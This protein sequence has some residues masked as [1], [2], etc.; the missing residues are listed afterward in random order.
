MPAG[1]HKNAAPSG[2]RSAGQSASL[3]NPAHL[4]RAARAALAPAIVTGRPR[5]QGRLGGANRRRRERGIERGAGL[6]AGGQ[7][8]TNCVPDSLPRRRIA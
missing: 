2:A 3:E 1:Q 7:S 8:Y 6:P 5:R 4:R